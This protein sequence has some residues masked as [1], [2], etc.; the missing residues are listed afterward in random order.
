MK[1]TAFIGSGRKKHTYRAAE[2]FLQKLQALGDVD[3]EN[4]EV[5]R[6][7]NRNLQR[8]L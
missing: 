5:K 3:Y 2:M 7:F 1:V 8:L 6:I 4:S